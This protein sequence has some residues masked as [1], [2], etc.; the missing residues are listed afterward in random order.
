MQ[1]GTLNLIRGDD[2]E[3]GLQINNPDGTPYN[4]SGVTWIFTARDSDYFSESVISK[5][6][7]NHPSPESGVGEIVFSGAETKTLGLTKY[8]FDIKLYDTG[9]KTTTLVAGDMLLYPR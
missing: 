6:G 4:L 8:Y 5:S 2:Q 7:S 9:Q 3:V 1:S